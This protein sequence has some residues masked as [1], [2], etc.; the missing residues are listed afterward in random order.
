M[1]RFLFLNNIKFENLRV[2]RFTYNFYSFFSQTNIVIFILFAAL[3]PSS[4][5]KDKVDTRKLKI[6]NESITDIYWVKSE[7]G[8]FKKNIYNDEV[9]IVMV[10]SIGSIGN[11]VPP[12]DVTIEE[13]KD[14]K[15]SI[16]IV[17][18]DSVDKYGWDSVYKRKLYVK[19]Y[20]IDMK[21]LEDNKWTII[22]R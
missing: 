7:S 12:W 5:I 16:F 14:K 22:Y 20:F 17:H 11:L 10:N 13:S 9:D 8:E 19:R 1:K 2:G 15:I 3:I 4:C 18:K 6:V 21:Y